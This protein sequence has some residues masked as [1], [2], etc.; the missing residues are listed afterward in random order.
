MAAISSGIGHMPLPICAC[1][2]RPQASPTST[3][4]SSY[5][6]IQGWFLISDLRIMGPASIEVWISSP[7]RSRNPVLM[8]MIRSDA[9]RI[10]SLRFTVVRRSSSMM[11]ILRVFGA[12][13][14]AASTRPKS[15]TANAVSSGPCI[16]GFT[17]YTDLVREFRWLLLPFRSCREIK[18][19]IMA[20]MMPSKISSPAWSRIA[21]L[22]IRWP[23]WRTSISER[24]GRENRLPLASV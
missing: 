11:P 23:T 12:M 2:G 20:S 16:L 21:G 22:V 1:P 3:F 19:A 8:K 5:A 13:P 14:R 7:V 6:W 9:A 10:H 17:T 15:S 24:P 4:Q 18:L